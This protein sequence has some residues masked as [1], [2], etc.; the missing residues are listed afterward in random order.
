[1]S[2][3]DVLASKSTLDPATGCINWGGAIGAGGYG[4]L[5]SDGKF[6]RAHRAAFQA[7]VGPIPEGLSV[8]H[9][10]DNRRCINPAHLFIGTHAENM[11]DMA[12]KGRANTLP[13]RAAQRR[14][15]LPRGAEH[16]LAVMTDAMVIEMRQ[17][18]RSG[19]THKAI[20]QLFGVKWQTA[21]DA[22]CGS[23]WTH[24]PDPVPLKF[25]RK[26]GNQ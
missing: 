2:L 21:R 24:V 16:R 20:A 8:C 22:I 5:L 11:A 14:E 17:M 19:Q 6:L 9:R 26:K 15:L 13:A 1:V 12:S 10:C 25:I 7:H 4:R 23:T 18:K 3:A